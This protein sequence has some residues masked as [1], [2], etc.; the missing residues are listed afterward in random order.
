MPVRLSSLLSPLGLLSLVC[1]HEPQPLA[2]DRQRA[3]PIAVCR[4]II[5]MSPEAVPPPVDSEQYATW[6]PPTPHKSI[7]K[8]CFS[9]IHG[10]E[11]EM[12]TRAIKLLGGG[13]TPY[14]T[15]FQTTHLVCA[16]ENFESSDKV[17]EGRKQSWNLIILSPDWLERSAVNG[18]FVTEEEFVLPKREKPQEDLQTAESA[19]EVATEDVIAEAVEESSKAAEVCLLEFVVSGE[20]QLLS[21]GRGSFHDEFC[22]FFFLH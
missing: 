4:P 11:K 19:A 12:Y 20:Q 17:R 13:V 18:Y 3:M 15:Q 5:R 8:V 1:T 7:V 16:P 22:F 9:G 21:M 2:H 6:L 14:M 10:R